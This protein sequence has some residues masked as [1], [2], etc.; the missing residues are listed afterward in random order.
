MTTSSADNKDKNED[1]SKLGMAGP[2]NPN[3]TSSHARLRTQYSDVDSV[4]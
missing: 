3:Q 4:R 1:K 2:V